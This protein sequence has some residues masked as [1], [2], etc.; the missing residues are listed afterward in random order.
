M[1][2]TLLAWIVIPMALVLAVLVL[3]VGLANAIRSMG[4]D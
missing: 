4:D 2:G 1:I 3:A